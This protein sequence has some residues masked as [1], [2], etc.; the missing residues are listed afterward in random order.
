MIISHK[1]KFIFIKTTKTAG[2]S[3]EVFLSRHCGENDIVTPFGVAEEGHVARNS[4]G[5]WN[6]IPEMLATGCGYSVLKRLVK[7]RKFHHHM[8]A[9]AVQ[10]L[11]P[12]KIWTRRKL[13]APSPCPGINIV[14]YSTRCVPILRSTSVMFLKRKTRR[15]RIKKNN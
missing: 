4:T 2:T 3:I 7:R 1:Y 12:E 10:S 9:R 13:N 6:P 15:V 14:P 11:V 8:P 5:F